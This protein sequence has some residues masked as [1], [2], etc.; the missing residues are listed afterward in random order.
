[1][2]RITTVF[3]L[4]I[5]LSVVSVACSEPEDKFTSADVQAT[6]EASVLQD[7]QLEATSEAKVQ[8]MVEATVQAISSEKTPTK[9]IAL[10]PTSIP[11]PTST[12]IPTPLPNKKSS[13]LS[14]E[15]SD[16]KPP[17]LTDTHFQLSNCKFD[18]SIHSNV[19]CG[20]LHVP[21]DRTVSDSRNI[22]LHIAIFHSESSN[23]EP[24][25]LIY[26]AG[27]PGQQVLEAIPLMYGDLVKPFVDNRDFIVFDQ[28]GTSYSKPNLDCSEIAD[29][30][31]QTLDKNISMEE[32]APMYLSS[33]SQC[34]NRLSSEQINLSA[35]NSVENAADLASLRKALGY[36]EWNLFGISY[37][38]R[39]ALTVMRDYPEGIRSVI[40]DSTYPL[41]VD[42]YSSIIPNFSRVLDKLFE[43]CAENKICVS[44]YPNLDSTFYDVAKRL[45]KEPISL[46][47][48]HPQTNRSVEASLNGDRFVNL[49]FLAMY[50]A[51]II[52]FIPKAIY[53]TYSN[54]PL[55]MEALI[56]IKLLN[57]EYLSAG[58]YFSVQC[59]EEIFFSDKRNATEIGEQY[60]KLKD[61]LHIGVEYDVCDNWDWRKA[62]NIENAAV[63]SEIPTLILAGDYDPITPPL[64]GKEVSQKLES[65][66][67]FEFPGTGHGVATSGR[68][69]LQLTKAFLKTPKLKPDDSCISNMSGPRF[70]SN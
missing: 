49:I 29:L 67:F 28:R 53:D 25:P 5:C 1:M 42:L 23:P 70:Y 48:K 62:H 14:T 2:N 59:G 52:P 69:Q 47:V 54:D 19:T 43:E 35:Y 11:N 45:N 57:D 36:D 22:S 61:Y 65:S 6:V 63:K 4:F 16:Y 58:M 26:L 8:M 44:S 60:P 13:N 21:E 55:I 10:T 39:L 20:Y 37:G 30:T 66:F 17:A 3:L 7:R 64:W 51:E 56:N 34:R 27:G 15:S 40:L 50:S 68:C 18:E 33:I 31:Y 38:T 46:N 41:H 24:D 9:E 12:K 32:F